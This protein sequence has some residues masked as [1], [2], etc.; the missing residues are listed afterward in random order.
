[1]DRTIVLGSGNEL[2]CDEGVG[3]HAV[4][5]LQERIDPAGASIELIEGGTSPDIAHLIQGA[6]RLVII[7]AVK[8][9]CEP[10]TIYRLPPDAIMSGSDIA[11]SVH[12][13]GIVDNLNMMKLLGDMPGQ[14]III[15]IEPARVEIGLDLSETLQQKM[16]KLIETVLEEIGLTSGVDNNEVKVWKC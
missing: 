16:P 7:D 15:G 6:D 4:R 14:T 1:M 5:A 8:G 13:I 2:M 12:Q 11:T 3:V 9:G 10:G